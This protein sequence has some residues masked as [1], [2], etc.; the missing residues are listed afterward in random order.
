MTYIERY[1]QA[2]QL[3]AYLGDP[4]DRANQVS[5]ARAAASDERDEYPAAACA[6]IDGWGFAEHYIPLAD[7]GRLDSFEEFM[8]LWRVL[9]RRDVTMAIAHLKTFLGAIPVWVAGSVQQRHELAELIRRPQQVALALTERA[10]GSDLVATELAATAVDR[11]YLLSGEKWLINN[12]TRSAALTVLARTDLAGGPRGSSLFLV[13]KSQL[14]QASYRH[15]ARAKTL[16]IRGADISGIRFDHCYL[17]ATALLGSAGSGLELTLKILQVT[18]TMCAGLSLGAGDTA[19]RVA[20]DF[21]LTRQIYAATVF[22]I[23]HAKRMLIEAFLDLLICDCVAIS[24]ARAIHAAPEQLSV[25]SAVVKYFVPTT[26]DHMIR[27]LAVVLGARH[28]LRGEQGAGIFQKFARDSAIIGLFDGSTVVNL[29]ALMQQLR[30][31]SARRAMA[32][33]GAAQPDHMRAVFDLSAPLPAFRPEQLE[34]LNRG[35]DMVLQGLDA[36]CAELDAACATSADPTLAAIRSLAA[37]MRVGVAALDHARAHGEQR[38]GVAF[39]SSLELYELA[40]RHCTLH[41]AAACLHMW[42]FNRLHNG[43]FFAGGAWLALCLQRLLQRLGPVESALPA[44]YTEHVADELVWR[45]REHQAFSI[46]P[47]ALD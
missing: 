45:Y 27:Q 42:W 10:H 38:Q 28:Y 3:E 36:T 25:W 47:L 46:I 23:P 29:H 31:L 37:Q 5:F 13:Q 44:S 9:A 17:P 34:L 7:G 6:Q 21:A 14:D 8:A 11:G 41:A 15:L 24:G 2:R 33:Q 39:S 32:S 16:G 22:A 43:A 40:K 4:S 12:A 30:Q 1:P 18:R 19:L 35:K 26:V 20:L